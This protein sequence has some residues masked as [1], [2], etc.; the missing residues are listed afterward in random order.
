M[1]GLIFCFHFPEPNVEQGMQG[2]VSSNHIRLRARGLVL[3]VLGFGSW[4]ELGCF[5][6]EDT[7]DDDAFG[8]LIH[9]DTP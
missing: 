1:S 6:Q 4:A 5:Q 9:V 2:R 8:T 3:Q 7:A